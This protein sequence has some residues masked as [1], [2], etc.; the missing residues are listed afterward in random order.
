MYFMYEFNLIFLNICNVRHLP[1]NLSCWNILPVSYMYLPTA[2]F[3][4]SLSVG[5]GGA[6]KGFTWIL[7]AVVFI[8]P[9]NFVT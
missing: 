4:W 3:I 1:V 6:L 9:K 8:A 2:G 5:G 7:W